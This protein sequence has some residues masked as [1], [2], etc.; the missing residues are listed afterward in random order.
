VIFRRFLSRCLLYGLVGLPGLVR[1]QTG[2]P[3]DIHFEH[4]TP[5]EGL[6]AAQ[7]R[8]ILQDSF[9]FI[10]IGTPDGLNRFDGSQFNIYRHKADDSNSL[11]N[12]IVNALALDDRGR[13]W[14]ATNKGLCF[15]DYADGLF[16]PVDIGRNN[17][18]QFDRNRVY[19]VVAGFGN[20]VWYSTITELHVL[21]PDGSVS[22]FPLPADVQ[23]NI[24]CLTED[25]RGRIWIGTNAGMALVFD[26]RHHAFTEVSLCGNPTRAKP[27]PALSVCHI[28]QESRDSFLVCTWS[29][30]LERISEAG[31]HFSV[32]LCPDTREPG[33]HKWIVPAICPSGFGHRFWVATY[34]GGLSLYDPS[35]GTF[36]RH[37]HHLG[38]DDLS[39]C[40]EFVNTVFTDNAGILWVGTDEGLD[41]YDTLVNRFS[42]VR[43]GGFRGRNPM[44]QHVVDLL[45]DRRDDA[46]NRLWLAIS[47]VGLVDYRLG[48][49]VRHVYS[50]PNPDD[51]GDNSINC[52]YQ[53][54]AGIL[55]LG[56]KQGLTRLDSHSGKFTRLTGGNGALLPQSISTIKEDSKKRIWVGTY[57]NGL[58]C[59]ETS[60]GK[61]AVYRHDRHLA[62]SLPDDHVFALTEDD[63]GRIWVGTQ[64]QGL[65]MLDNGEGHWRH[66]RME[67][68][69]V[70]SLPDN[71]VYALQED[72]ATGR[73]WIATEN[74]LAVMNLRDFSLHTYSSADGLC[75]ND[76]FAI[77]M[78]ADRHLW[79]ATN[80]GISDFDPDSVKFRNYYMR[81]GLPRNSF[82]EAFRC[83]PNGNMLLGFPGGLVLFN[84]VDMRINKRVPEVVITA[85]KIFDKNYPLKIH[86]RRPEPLSLNY[87]QD[88]ITFEFSALNFTHSKNNNYAYWLEG[89]DK[90]WIY[91][92]GRTS[93]TY[94]NLDG[95]SY[96]F[97][98]K[99]ANNDGI[100]NEA[101]TVL[102][103]TVKPPFRK[104]W[105]FYF[106]MLALILSAFYLLYRYR[107]AQVLEI[108]Q[109]RADIAR[110]LH[111][112]IGST[113][114][115][116]FMMSRMGLKNDRKT[117][118]QERPAELLSTISRASQQAMELMSDIVWS[119]NPANDGM[120]QI[121]VRMREYAGE[122]L[123]ASDI[124]L[125]FEAGPN[126]GRV[127][128]SLKRRKELL[129]IFKEAVNN[130]A[131]HSGARDAWVR[132]SCRANLL[133]LIVEDNGV[134][135]EPGKNGGGNGLRNMAERA[136]RLGASLSVA[137]CSGGGTMVRLILPLDPQ[138]EAAP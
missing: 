133:E 136:G 3:P 22:S 85:C 5:A 124:R 102:P 58:Y 132:I 104:T 99:A 15:F 12:N 101:G 20:R 123:D 54:S 14:V 11:N 135:L 68:N 23:G 93:A 107:V 8:S 1:P 24:S 33:D 57:N 13:V 36:T 32:S 47:G 118:R 106:L 131:K 21:G 76:V 55:W 48:A 97:H 119:V 77:T 137:C 79:L 45:A 88:M 98:V 26:T 9:G 43:I 78:S 46:H 81:D 17:G 50:H 117:V 39:L 19:A 27:N 65:C 94:T 105:E 16:H 84:G 125:L 108:Q 127:F 6:S 35:S 63:G 29:R 2:L 75:N 82:D 56:G 112:D 130:L 115:S 111:D 95:G 114:S 38:R 52:L 110:D 69:N 100:W 10:W 120:E 126:V 86:D 28:Y 49:G 109:V 87:R 113:L 67:E 70:N 51:P 129:L 40:S 73:L 60:T 34:G 121:L 83:L 4:Y 61:W 44:L 59:Y 74:G 72:K 92:G 91:C 31:G 103:L 80:N 116:I 64:N 66:F 62:G 25:D 128:L 30:G 96:I 18:E 41:K 134:G 71:N 138:P 90:D 42:I 37:L 53:D 7:V 122:T 89:F